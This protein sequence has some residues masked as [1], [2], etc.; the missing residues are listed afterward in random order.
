[1]PRSILHCLLSLLL[2]VSQ[3][4]ALAHGLSHWHPAQQRQSMQQ[5]GGQ[6]DSP[7]LQEFCAECAADAQ[8]DVALPLPQYIAHVPQTA[9]ASPLAL[10][11]D[12]VRAQPIHAS[13]PRGPPRA[14]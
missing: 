9:V 4:M 3:Q 8:L 7:A 2:L 13:Y 1:M 10:G 5:A 6:P 14:N 11:A 12:R